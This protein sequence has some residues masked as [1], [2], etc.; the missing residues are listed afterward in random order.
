MPYIVSSNAEGCSGFAVV[1]E[2]ENSP[3]PGGCH[4]TKSDAIAHMVALKAEYEDGESRQEM[5]IEDEG[6]DSEENLLP[7]QT[8][9]Y[10]LYESIAESFG[11][12]NQGNGADGAHYAPV[13]PFQDQGLICASCVFYEGGQRCE[14]VEGQIKPL[15]ICKLWIIEESLLPI[16]GIKFV[17]GE[18]EEE[19]AEYNTRASVNLVAPAFMKAS[20]RRGLALHEEGYSGDGLR[21]QTVEDARK[22]ANGE[23]LSPEK[24]RKISPWIARH[25]VDLDAVQGDEITAGLVAMLLWGGGSSKASASRA[26][27][28]AERIVS[29]LEESREQP[30]DKLGRFGSSSDSSDPEASSFESTKEAIEQNSQNY[31]AILAQQRGYK[32]S[33][34]QEVSESVNAYCGG[35]YYA[36]N[37]SL[38]NPKSKDFEEEGPGERNEWQKNLREGHISRLDQAIAGSPPTTADLVV[39]R[40]VS[41]KR[42]IASIEKAG[43]GGTYIDKGFGSTS[44]SLTVAREAMSGELF[45]AKTSAEGKV[46][47]IKI[48]KG[49][50]A[51]TAAGISNYGER[52]VILPRN[53]KFKITKIGYDDIE[54]EVIP[55]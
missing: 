43:V 50:K 42:A 7:R 25:T 46:I 35:S 11:Q 20:A 31:D 2:G 17:D 52:E 4:K 10:E 40:G 12:W 34:D 45:G 44:M 30:R 24:W 49:S 39:H 21:P 3:I 13:S 16:P 14:I 23:A 53:S 28:Y 55:E 1:K 26:K 22:M 6:D 8:A 29:Q 5:E 32:G 54:M 9:M 15:G 38:R 36:M 18:P 27:S 19:P 48:P 47:T 37:K 41:G 51:L 33:L